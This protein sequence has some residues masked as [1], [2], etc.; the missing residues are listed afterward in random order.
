MISDSNR[1]GEGCL[2]GATAT[3]RVL[4]ADTDS[5]TIDLVSSCSLRKGWELE[6]LPLGGRFDSDELV[7]CLDTKAFD[8]VIAD[9]LIPGLDGLSLVKRIRATNPQQPIIV[10]SATHSIPDLLALLREGVSDILQ[11]PFDSDSFVRAVDRAVSNARDKERGEGL[12]RYV[13]SEESEIVLNSR[14][15]AEIQPSL[16]ILDRLLAARLIDLGAK[17]RLELAFQELVANA[18]EHGNLELKSELKEQIDATGL[19]R[20]SLLK[21][22]RLADDAYGLRE[23]RIRVRLAGGI[24]EIGIEDQGVGFVPR[25]PDEWKTGTGVPHGRGLAMIYSAADAVDFSIVDSRK[26]GTRVVIRKKLM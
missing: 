9:L 8:V 17:L 10:V 4:C 14:E 15:L 2:R 20:F 5:G 21:R 26:G 6:T 19:D 16:G 13:R 1:S 25:V 23:V 7:R 22:E 18:L 12:Q 11:K 3:P 24:L